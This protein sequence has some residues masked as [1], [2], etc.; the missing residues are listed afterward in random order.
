MISQRITDAIDLLCESERDVAKYVTREGRRS[1][2]VS[3]IERELQL[4]LTLARQ[5]AAALRSQAERLHTA[6]SPYS[7]EALELRDLAKRLEH[8]V[9]ERT[10]GVQR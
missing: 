9:R 4:P 2:L 8:H 6:G 3:A 7:R 5:C 1:G 10:H